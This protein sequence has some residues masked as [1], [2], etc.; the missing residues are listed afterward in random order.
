MSIVSGDN[1]I[2]SRNAPIVEGIEYFNYSN[3][4][5]VITDRLGVEMEI[6]R[7]ESRP[8]RLEDR[9][10]VIV[11]VTR[12]VDPRRVN[13]PS[14]DSQLACDQEYLIAF[15]Q[16]VEQ[17]RS[18]FNEYEPES[19]QVRMTIQVEMRFDFIDF[20][21]VHKSNLLGIT[22]RETSN[23]VE[24][25]YGTNPIGY[26]NDQILKEL[27]EI[28]HEADGYTDKG[29][30]TLFSARLIDSHNRVGTLWTS[31][32]GDVT[33]IIPVKDE[34]QQEG[35]YL[36][37]G[38]RL[39]HK[40]FIP[41]DELL[42]PKKLLSYNLHATEREARKHSTGEYTASVMSGNEKLKK[43]NNDL[44]TEQKKLVLKVDDLEMKARV[45]KLNRAQS[46]FKQTVAME[47]L[48]EYRAEDYVSGATRFITSIISNIKVVATLLQLL[49]IT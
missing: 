23:V 48:K 7:T 17:M 41:I 35:L 25:S 5:V 28:D 46:D 19:H 34:E 29:I 44:K 21:T 31:G 14:T 40:R 9:G 1:W 3:H 26:I 30:R 20:K 15:K 38:L 47:K 24:K 16:K 36:A 10:K 32:F 37:G 33:R 13:V 2:H 42:D 18:R 27:D 11:R 22:I 43:E 45:E 12:L 8:E 39:E 6:L 49:K 4:D